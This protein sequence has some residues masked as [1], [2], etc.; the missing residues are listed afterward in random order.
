MRH[1]TKWINLLIIFGIL[2]ACVKEPFDQEAYYQARMQERREKAAKKYNLEKKK[3]TASQPQK[4]V[5][6]QPKSIHLVRI[7][8]DIS[9][10]TITLNNED[11]RPLELATLAEMENN[12]LVQI[13]LLNDMAVSGVDSAK[14]AKAWIIF[15]EDSKNYLDKAS[16]LENSAPVPEQNTASRIIEKTKSFIKESPKI[17][18]PPKPSAR[19]FEALQQEIVQE[20]ERL[21]RKIAEE[22]AKQQGETTIALQRMQLKELQ[23]SQIIQMTQAHQLYLLRAQNE[24][25]QQELLMIR[26]TLNSMNSGPR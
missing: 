13:K 21:E 7:S 25:L 18:L 12:L 1:R 17:I 5:A 4:Q 11:I 20:K 9:S 19:A 23:K 10:E 16:M 6:K 14:Y 26:M 24:R 8:S 2:I 15:E 3:E 22:A